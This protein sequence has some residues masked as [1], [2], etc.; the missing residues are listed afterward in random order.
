MRKD[1]LTGQEASALNADRTETLSVEWKLDFAL[2]RSAL[3]VVL[4]L[5]G[6]QSGDR[7]AAGHAPFVLV[8]KP[9]EVLAEALAELGVQLDV[10]HNV[11]EEGAVEVGLRHEVCEPLGFIHGAPC[12]LSEP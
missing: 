10:D 3:K 9:L 8:D 7:G 2:E 12:F 11:F 5:I 6:A 1:L 4:L